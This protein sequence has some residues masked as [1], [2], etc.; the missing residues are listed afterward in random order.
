[1]ALYHP[2]LDANL[3]NKYLKRRRKMYDQEAAGWIYLVKGRWNGE[4]FLKIRRSIDFWRR[5]KEH[6]RCRIDEWTIL[7]KWWVPLS[8]RT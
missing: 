5:M 2:R 7:G 6:A 4:E 8:H 3:R 1:M